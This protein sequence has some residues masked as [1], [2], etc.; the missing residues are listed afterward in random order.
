MGEELFK[1]I[2]LAVGKQVMDDAA[3]DLMEEKDDG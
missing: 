3:N 2:G 1:T